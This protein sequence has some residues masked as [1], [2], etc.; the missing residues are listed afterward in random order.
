MNKAILKSQIREN[1]RKQRMQLTKKQIEDAAKVLAEHVIN[2][3]DPQL[4]EEI[5]KAD[6]IALYRSV[7]GELSC[8]AITEH[9]VKAGKTICFPRVKGDTMDF[10]EIKDLD[11]D[12]SLGSYDIPEPKND[13]RKVY[14]NDIDLIFVPAVAYTQDGARLGQGGGYYDRYL[15]QYGAGKKPVTVG[16]CY[17]FQVYSALPVESHD[18]MVDYV[19]VVSSE[20]HK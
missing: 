19:L 20:E 8:D 7:N 11:A 12:F 16:I 6:T 17:D 14:P 9:F 5:A 15:N 18:Y 13:M 2:D 4:V 3:G 10:Y 1:V